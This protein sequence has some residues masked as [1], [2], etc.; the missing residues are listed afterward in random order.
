MNTSAKH[1]QG[2][3][4]SDGQSKHY[5]I[6][7]SQGRKLAVVYKAGPNPGPDTRLFTAAPELLEALEELVFVSDEEE[8]EVV[9]PLQRAREVISK[10]KGE[11]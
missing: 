8:P 2:P 9:I 4:H 6:L 5:E 11:A 7:D 3:F 10:A 1:T